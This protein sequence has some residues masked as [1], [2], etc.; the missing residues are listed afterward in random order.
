MVLCAV[1]E[2]VIAG[3][4]FGKR[5]SSGKITKFPASLRFLDLEEIVL[6]VEEIVLRVDTIP[7][8]G[9]AQRPQPTTGLLPN[10]GVA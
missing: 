9:G 6:R 5:F 1:N 3:E 7:C 10:A 4:I 8:G 2:G